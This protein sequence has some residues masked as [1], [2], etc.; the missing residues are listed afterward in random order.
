RY[1]DGIRRRAV[2]LVLEVSAARQQG[3][4]GADTLAQVA[5]SL[6]ELQSYAALSALERLY[7]HV[8][9]RVRRAAVRA[10]RHLYFKRSFGLLGKGL[11]DR[12]T[13]VREAAVEALR[14]L[15]FAHA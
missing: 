12:E 3:E 4:V 1:P 11:A 9:T 15:H 10:L 5:Q 14:G 2:N 8:E 6:G 13:V 7:L